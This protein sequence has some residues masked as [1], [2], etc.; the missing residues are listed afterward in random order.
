MV[1]AYVVAAAVA[2]CA[3]IGITTHP[4]LDF[5][6][7]RDRGALVFA[8]GVIY[9]L[10][11]ITGVAVTGFAKYVS[12]EPLTHGAG[13]AWA[14]GAV[15]GAAA[16]LLLRLEITSFGLSVFRPARLLLQISLDRFEPHLDAGA[17]RHIARQ[18]GDLRPLTLCR[19]SWSLFIRYVAPPALE[20][21][22]DALAVGGWLRETHRRALGAE[23]AEDPF[24]G[25][26][27]I[28]A[29]ERLRVNIE[30]LIVVNLD[31]SV[32]LHEDVPSSL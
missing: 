24:S 32:D 15:Y 26:E 10:Y 3:A 21:H 23:G 4:K 17:R 2:A 31:V 22:S 27:A 28:E 8:L 1:I 16:F 25:E 7:A 18:V 29:Q 6:W 19:I 30:E 13:R 9:L 12:W 11:A 14:N 20:R 5:W